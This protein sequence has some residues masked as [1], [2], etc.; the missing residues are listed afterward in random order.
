M[1]AAVDIF[2]DRESGVGASEAL[3]YCGK[4]PRCSSLQ[5]YLRKVGEAG[6]RPDE[7]AR[8]QWGHRLEPVVRDWLSEELGQVIVPNPPRVVSPDYPF[9]FAHLDGDIPT[10]R[11]VA[12]IKT[13]DKYLAQEFG[14]VETDEVP[15]RYVLQCTHQ[16]IV[17]G[18]R[19][20]HLAVL[21]GGNDARR[22]VV[23]YDET[24]AASLIA[25]ATLFWRHVESRNPPEAVNLHDADKL[26]PISRGT[27][28]VSDQ[29]T[30]IALTQL[31]DVRSQ[32]KGLEAKADDLELTVKKFMGDADYLTDASGKTLATWKSQN[33]NGF[34]TK[35]F[36]EDYPEL[37]EQYRKVSNFRVFRIK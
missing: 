28:T 14:E 17:T 7:D 10:L 37:A 6:E 18:Y 32:I 31:K 30:I 21:I 5:L 16:M 35:A 24:L 3:A 2:K 11:E 20:A 25:R 19:R 27:E 15:I 23:D 8:Q 29:S 4:D 12:E 33:R 22:Y 26:W 13:S 34:D 1:N 9:M 36:S